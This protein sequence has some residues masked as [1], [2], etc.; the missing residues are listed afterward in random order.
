[1]DFTPDPLLVQLRKTLRTVL[2]TVP[3][4]SEMHGAPVIDGVRGPAQSVL[5][6]LDAAHFER[7]VSAGGLGLG[8]TAGVLLSE[9][10]GRAARGNPYRA[11]ALAADVGQPPG[12]ALAGF[13]ALPVGGGVTAAPVTGGWELS[14]AVTVD[15]PQ[16]APLLVATQIDDAAVLVAVPP[17]AR[18]LSLASTCWPPVAQFEATPITR[19]DI[20]GNLDDTPTGPLARGRLRQAAYL[21]GIGESAHH[22]AVRYTRTRRQFGTRLR[23]LP[24]VAFPLAQALVALRAARVA[25]Y[26]GAWLVDCASENP[27]VLAEVAAVA[28]V[29]TAAETTRE[30][31]R[32]SM[33]ACGVRAMTT[34]LGLHRFFR[35][36]AAESSRYGQPSGL[37][38]IVGAARLDAA[39]RTRLIGLD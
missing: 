22:L 1:M 20:A 29:A 21:L 30:V 3:L 5:E 11:D 7:P 28:A 36:A 16:P 4:R 37:W 13:E 39:R 35:L 34:E 26:H 17:K 18:G 23:D 15:S 19:M 27:D 33:Q 38:R 24:A 6:E 14:G 25:V 32:V 10:L 2:A 9:E 8:L 12:A 31:V